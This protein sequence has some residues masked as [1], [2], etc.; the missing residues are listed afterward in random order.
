LQLD[1]E[2]SAKAYGSGTKESFRV[3]LQ[4]LIR[5]LRSNDC[6]MGEASAAPA[7]KATPATP[8]TPKTP[9]T[10]GSR[11]KAPRSRKKKRDDSSDDE[12]TP[13]KKQRSAGPVKTEANAIDELVT[14]AA[15]SV[16]DMDE[17]AFT[18][19]V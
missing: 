13:S 17:S 4:G 14:G 11:A 19:V 16:E 6:E 12:F 9:K 8:K 10:A 18:D 5:N 1:Y 2:L 3:A 7:V 15:Q